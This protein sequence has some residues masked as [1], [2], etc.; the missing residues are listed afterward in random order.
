EDT[1][2]LRAGIEELVAGR[3]DVAVWT[4]AVQIDHVFA[5][6]ADRAELVASALRD[7]T[8]VAAIGPTAAEALAAR[9]VPADLVASPPKLGPLVALLAREAPSLAAAKR[10]RRG[11][12]ATPRESHA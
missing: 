9:G 8:V 7:A 5:V 10:A 6:A 2:P 12:A 1:A 11:V 4:T 3:I